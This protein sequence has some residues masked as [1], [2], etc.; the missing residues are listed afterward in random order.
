MRAGIPAHSS[1]REVGLCIQSNEPQRN[2]M[3]LCCQRKPARRSKI[4][5]AGIA[6]NLAN[7]EGKVT[8]AYPLFKRKQ[9]IFRCLCSNMDHTMPERRRKPGS[10]RPAGKSYRSGILHPQD[11]ARVIACSERI[12]LG[13]LLN[14]PVACQSERERSATSLNPTCKHF[15]MQRPS[16]ARFPALS[17]QRICRQG[18]ER[19]GTAKRWVD[20]GKMGKRHGRGT[21]GSAV[22][23][24]YVPYSRDS[25]WIVHLVAV[26][27]HIGVKN[28]TNTLSIHWFTV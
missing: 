23:S 12:I 16:F 2:T 7:H 15:A 8:A 21:R 11:S 10:I 9:G 19:P 1:R 26:Q 13:T 14:H 20:P 3:F 17:R 27:P 25:Q 24:F 4:E 18:S 5:R 22:C 28:G 6:C